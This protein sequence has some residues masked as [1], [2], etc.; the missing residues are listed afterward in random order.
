VVTVSPSAQKDA[1]IDKFR[2][3]QGGS[4]RSYKYQER[5]LFVVIAMVLAVSFSMAQ[6]KTVPLK[7]TGKATAEA[8]PA[9]AKL[10]GGSVESVDGRSRKPS[11]ASL[12][13][14]KV[15]GHWT[16]EVRNPDGTIAASRE[17]QNS[18][19]V[20]GGLI[21]G[22]ILTH[23]RKPVF[24]EV[25]LL[26]NPSGSVCTSGNPPHNAD[27]H[28]LEAGF[29]AGYPNQFGTLTV[30][31]PSSGENDGKL[32]LQGSA[33][34]SFAGQIGQVETT[35]GTTCLP[36]ACDTGTNIFTFADLAGQPVNIQAGQTI[37]VTVVISFS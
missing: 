35:L 25:D 13:G 21:L 34:A 10:S 17:F 23:Q 5:I 9:A 19:V 26:N 3:F 32:V 4:V 29:T 20:S 22:A 31:M 6:E 2:A 12:G 27:C 37:D 36:T 16:I 15:H 28:I 1:L 11:G 14:I 8:I 18:L 7:G 30:S 33:T 24:W